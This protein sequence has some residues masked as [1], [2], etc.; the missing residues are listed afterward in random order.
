MLHV[1][2]YTNNL[3]PGV[4]LQRSGVTH[5]LAEGIAVGP[6]LTGQRF[7]DDDHGLRAG[8]VLLREGTAFQKRDSH[9]LKVIG[10]PDSITTDKMLAGWLIG[11]AFQQIVFN[12]IAST[13]R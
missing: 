12:G 4:F 5:A 8:P 11:I 9:R 1:L 6:I 2:H 10:S 13:E 7:I 3:H